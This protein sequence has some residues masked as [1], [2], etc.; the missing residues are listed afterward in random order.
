VSL[1]KICFVFVLSAY[2]LSN[3]RQWAF[4]QIVEYLKFMNRDPAFFK[5][6]E[7]IDLQ[8]ALKYFFE[9]I[10]YRRFAKKNNWQK[11]CNESKEKLEE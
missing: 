9:T 3:I 4:S 6:D 8:F 2:P 7:L 1:I 5:D 10:S 11:M